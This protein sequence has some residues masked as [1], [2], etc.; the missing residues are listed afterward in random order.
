MTNICTK[1]TVR[2]RPIKNGQVSLYLD[3]Y[4][5]VRHPKTGKPTIVCD[6]PLRDEAMRDIVEYIRNRP[7]TFP[8]WHRSE[9]AR[10]F[11]PPVFRNEKKSKGYW[12]LL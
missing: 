4:P 11:S 3:Y 5:A 8:E 10:L 9:T 1:V 12:F 7:D 2:K 6:R